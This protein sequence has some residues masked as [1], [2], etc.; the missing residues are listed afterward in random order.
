MLNFRC[1]M[2]SC[3]KTVVWRILFPYP[4][5]R[6][7]VCQ[8]FLAFQLSRYFNLTGIPTVKTSPIYLPWFRM[9]K[10]FAKLTNNLTEIT[11][12]AGKKRKYWK[13][14]GI[15]GICQKCWKYT[16]IFENWWSPLKG[17]ARCSLWFGHIHTFQK[18]IQNRLST[19]RGQDKWLFV[20][21]GGQK[22]EKVDFDQFLPKTHS[23]TH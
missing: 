15:L 17:Y 16:G 22:Y 10:N 19:L 3:R 12:S 13:Y 11:E 1:Q 7:C 8:K 5:L 4:R 18:C 23:K 2:T 21:I 6:P 14:T 9:S 20:L